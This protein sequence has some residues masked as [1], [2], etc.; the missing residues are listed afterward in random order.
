MLRICFIRFLKVVIK[1]MFYIRRNQINKDFGTQIMK[2]SIRKPNSNLY[3]IISPPELKVESFFV[4]ER[5]FNYAKAT[6]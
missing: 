1:K 2:K 3:S 5:V 6:E 4:P